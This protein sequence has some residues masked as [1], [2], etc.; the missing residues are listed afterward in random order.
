MAI[1]PTTAHCATRQRQSVP[2]TIDINSLK[3]NTSEITTWQVMELL[4]HKSI[5]PYGKRVIARTYNSSTLMNGVQ[6]VAGSNPAVPIN[7]SQCESSTYKGMG[8]TFETTLFL[9]VCRLCAAT[10]CSISLGRHRRSFRR[11]RK[12]RLRMWYEHE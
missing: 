4:R 6:G 12:G 8:S 9:F 2:E 10:S 3:P 5:F 11:H 7:K 1:Y